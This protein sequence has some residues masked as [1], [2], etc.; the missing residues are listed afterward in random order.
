MMS[1]LIERILKGTTGNVEVRRMWW[2]SQKQKYDMTGR[3]FT[4]DLKRIEEFVSGGTGDVFHGINTRKPGASSGK[5]EDVYEVV[6]VIVDVDFKTT[7]QEVFERALNEFPLKPTFI[8]DSG[9]GRH[10]YWFFKTPI[11]VNGDAR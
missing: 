9:N 4:R 3:V 8:V 10:L 11:L 7:P 6:C 2:D 1:I 5:K